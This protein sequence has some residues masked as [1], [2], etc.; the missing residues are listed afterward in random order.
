MA[1]INTNLLAPDVYGDLVREK[2]AG[3][4]IVAQLAK[5]NADLKGQ[6]GET[7][8]FPSW[9]YI[10]D[11]TDIVLGQSMTTSALRQTNKPVTIKMIA[12]PGVVINDYD[13][14]VAL[15]N[16]I[17]EAAGQQ[18]LSIARKKDTDLIAAVKAAPLQGSL[19]LEGN[20]TFTELVNGLKFFGDDANSEDVAAI[21]VHSCYWPDLLGMDAFTNL[22]NSVV[23]Q[24]NGIMRNGT[25]GSFLG[26]PVLCS[27]RL[28]DATT[29]KHMIQ[30]IKKGALAVV[31]KEN[32]FVEI[33]R[34]A[35][36]RQSV[37][38]TSQFI[39]SAVVD[40]SGV[41]CLSH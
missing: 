32:P 18:A 37:I 20:V 14:E 31:E 1:L 2:V 30:I 7:I 12:A 9:Q 26:I 25:V 5:T 39:A 33:S 24:N 36:K 15:G 4:V 8:N 10:G 34:D 6:P 41:V 22:N 3:R 11:A 28:Y 23:A 29:Q 13:N 21:V 16:A 35:S 40:D 38:Y 27:D 19:S 17:D